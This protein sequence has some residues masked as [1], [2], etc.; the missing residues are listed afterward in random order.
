MATHA[1]GVPAE[2]DKGAQYN[3][4]AAWFRSPVAVWLIAGSCFFVAIYLTALFV[5]PH[6]QDR[7]AVL[8]ANGFGSPFANETAK[9]LSIALCFAIA[10][11]IPKLGAKKLQRVEGA[12]SRFALHRGQAILF[13]TVL[14]VLVRLALLPI[15]RVPQP[16]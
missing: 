9:W 3:A 7:A 12:I 10:F 14:P 8:I 2:P 6:T 11:A 16:R 5:E 15:L 1:V 4:K 13:C